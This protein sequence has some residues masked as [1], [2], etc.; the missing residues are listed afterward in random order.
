MKLTDAERER[1]IRWDYFRCVKGDTNTGLVSRTI[2]PLQECLDLTD[3]E[4]KKIVLALPAVLGY[5]YTNVV[6]KKLKPLKR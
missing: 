2:E 6:D 1:I 5:N 3:D 4:L